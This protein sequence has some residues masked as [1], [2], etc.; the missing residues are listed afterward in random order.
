MHTYNTSPFFM[1]TNEHVREPTYYSNN[2]LF[3]KKTHAIKNVSDA[4]AYSAQF[5]ATDWRRSFTI[6][7]SPTYLAPASSAAAARRLKRASPN[8]RV[9]ALVC[10]PVQ[11]AF[12]HFYVSLPRFARSLHYLLDVHTHVLI[13]FITTHLASS[14]ITALSHWT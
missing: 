3:D 12:S 2:D 11:R 7:K 4:N 10:D 5:P 6:D 9:I 1:L 8:A 13:P 14:I